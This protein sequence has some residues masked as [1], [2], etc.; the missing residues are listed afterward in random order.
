MLSGISTSWLP[1]HAHDST[2]SDAASACARLLASALRAALAAFLS[3]AAASSARRSASAS[4]S[5]MRDNRTGCNPSP[6]TQHVH[7]LLLQTAEPPL[8]MHG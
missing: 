8:C 5:C 7:Q 2:G 1:P 3:A 6:R 4:A